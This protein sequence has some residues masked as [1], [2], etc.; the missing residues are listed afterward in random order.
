MAKKHR[1]VHRIRL[2]KPLYKKPFFWVLISAGILVVVVVYFLFFWSQFQIKN[3][4]ISGNEKV[5]GIELKNLAS[6]L[7]SRKFLFFPTQSFFL[8]D[9]SDIS[10]AILKQYPQIDS[11]QVSKKLPDSLNIFVAERKPFAL[12]LVGKDYYFIDEKGIVFER[13]ERP[14]GYF[15]IEQYNQ[16]EVALGAEAVAKDVAGKISQAQKMLADNFDVGI[17]SVEIATSERLNIKTGEGWQVYLN[18]VSDF[19]AQLLKLKTLLEKEISA[20]E[21][22]DLRYIDMRFKDRAYYK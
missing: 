22:K 18:L 8:V 15:I 10:G 16:N 14:A 1:H 19:E 17:S 7:V 21:R 5:S 13:T 20:K 3:I 2:K 12:L 6:Q 4:S 11:A 9:S